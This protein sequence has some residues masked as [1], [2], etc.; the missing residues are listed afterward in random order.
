MF[1]TLI[2]GGGAAGMSCALIIGSAK[3]KSFAKDKK[4]GIIVHQKN[5][6]L[7]KCTI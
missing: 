7:T 5:I 1:E 2:I 3:E 4:T 6:S